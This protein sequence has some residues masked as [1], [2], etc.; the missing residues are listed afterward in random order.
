MNAIV[1][2]SVDPL[3]EWLLHV[4]PVGLVLGPNIIREEQLTP[5]RQNAVDTEAVKLLLAPENEEDAPVLPDPWQFFSS[6]LSWKARFVAGAPGGPPLPGTE[7][8]GGDND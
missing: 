6:V 2:P 5:A 4:R 1:N 7:L 3:T 8:Q